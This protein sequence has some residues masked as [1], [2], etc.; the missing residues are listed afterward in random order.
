LRFPAWSR[1]SLQQ[2][3]K[4]TRYDFDVLI[5]I[6]NWPAIRT[7]PWSQL[8][9][10]RAIENQ[11]YVAGVNRIGKDGNNIPYDGSSVVLDMFGSTLSKTKPNKTSVETITLSQKALS[12][13]RIKFP[14]LLDADKVSIKN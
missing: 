10:A 11:V 3:T 2:K 4:G 6:A 13:A 12:E 7:F 1:N 5:Y 14:V 9:I 8:L